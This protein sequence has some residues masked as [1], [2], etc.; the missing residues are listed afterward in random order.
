MAEARE[1]SRP[2]GVGTAGA[3]YRK[4]SPGP[5]RPALE[6]ASHQRA[7]ICGAMIAAV[8]ERG[9]NAVTVRELVRLAGV[10]THTFYEH[11]GG[12]EGC[13]LGTYELAMRRAAR[14]VVASQNG[15]DDSRAR[16]RLA[17][18]TLA[19]EL[20]RQPGAARLALLEAPPNL[21]PSALARMRRAD[22]VLEAVARGSLADAAGGVALPPLLAKGIVAGLARVVRARLLEGRERELPELAEELTEWVLCCCSEAVEAL[23]RLEPAPALAPTGQLDFG[24]AAAS[25]EEEAPGD[26]RALILAAVERLAAAEGYRQLTVPRIRAMAGVSRGSFDAHFTGVS[27]CFLAAC[28]LRAGRLFGEAF[29]AGASASSWQGGVHRASVALCAH[30]ARQ[31]APA[32][33]PLAEIVAAGQEGMRCRE[34]L[35][36][37]AAER[38]RAAAPSAQR[39]GELVTEASAGAIW[40]ILEHHVAAG[41]ARSLPHAAATLSLLAI[42]PAVGV[43]AAVEAIR[44]EQQRGEI[45][46]C[47]MGAA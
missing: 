20:A 8:A 6:V 12:K 28:E 27:D 47:A 33:L 36:A 13:L 14:R 44:R 9:Y 45:A 10:S 4:L 29:R 15:E 17:F 37:A 34:R 35:I 46:G 1:A 43:S 18:S 11:F 21:G 39:P 30:I 31:P 16:L 26:E 41:R 7:R 24:G 25:G 3:L 42:A 5:A 32:R 23:D 2:A 19:A 22:G 40:G 38:L